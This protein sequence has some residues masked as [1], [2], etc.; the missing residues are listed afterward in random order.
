M[1]SSA[2]YKRLVACLW[3]CSSL[4][5]V[6]C[7]KTLVGGFRFLNFGVDCVGEICAWVNAV[8]CAKSVYRF[9]AVGFLAQA[10]RAFWAYPWPIEYSY[11]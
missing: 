7:L 1:V 11:T 2:A 9:A 4:S 5:T 10:L 6:R 8:F 3:L